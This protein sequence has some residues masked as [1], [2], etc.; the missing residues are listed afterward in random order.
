MGASN[1]RWVRLGDY[2]EQFRHKC[3][4][5]DAIVS[6]V[7]INKQFI[8][9]RANLEGIDIS[10]YYLVPPTFFACNL[11][12]I[13]RDER[14]P[15]AYNNTS[16]NLVVT[17]AYYVF[18]VKKDKC[19]EILNEYLY[20]IFCNKEI[21]RLTW[22]YTDSSIRGN[23]RENR[24]L[25]IEIPLPSPDEQQKVV[26]VW[27]VFREIKEQNEAK[28][29]PL[30]QVCQSYIQKAK[31][32]NVDKYRI[33]NAIKVVDAINKEGYPYDVLGLN[34][35][36]VFMP[37]IASMDTINTNKYKVIK[38]GE[39][40]FS[41]MQT[42]RDKCIRIALYD[43]DFPALISPAYTTFILDENEPILP[44]YFM[45]IFKNPEMDR[46]GWFYS[47]SSVRANLDWDRFIDIEI[48]L[49]P[50]ELQQAIVNIYKC[51]NEAKQI[52][53][54]ADRLSREVC[55]VLLQH[56]IHS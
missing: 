38:K 26:N 39:F 40:A 35:N 46:L 20:I 25:D 31:K 1:V 44:E 19:D 55:P 4:N 9:T 10:G 5:N 6:G 42:G 41:G 21:D 3:A 12:H 22:F 49:L 43:K 51:A 14:L 45:M 34:N 32:N 24:F 36:K 17:S 11:M 29:A 52:A 16:T 47:D 7:D 56:V 13:G 27:R 8:P 37:T 54:E 50:I 18:H 15:I 53:E 2:I 48:P 28:A 23:L 33:G 30:M